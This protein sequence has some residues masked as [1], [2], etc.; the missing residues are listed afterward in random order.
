MELPFPAVKCQCQQ[1]GQGR[2]AEPQVRRDRQP[3]MDPAQRPQEIIVEAQRQP[4][5]PGPEELQ[6]LGLQGVFHQP[7]SLRR[8]L[9]S[10]RD[11]S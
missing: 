7:S 1:G 11:C 10:G 9:P 3:G 6:R 2:R 4:E 5:G 8:K